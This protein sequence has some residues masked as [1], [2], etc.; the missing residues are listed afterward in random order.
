MRV[1]ESDDLLWLITDLEGGK[2][3]GCLKAFCEAKNSYSAVLLYRGRAV[4]CIYESELEAD[5]LPTEHSLQKMLMDCQTPG[6]QLLMYSL[7]DEVILAMSA[8][9]VGYP[10]ERA[11]DLD[12]RSYTDFIMRWFVA[13]QQTACLAF[14]LPIREET[15]LAL[16]HKGIIAGAFHVQNQ[17]FSRDINFIFNLI[18]QDPQ[19]RVEASILPPEI[20]SGYGFKL[21]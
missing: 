11:D 6:T 9:F 2:R 14:S 18:Q 10:V 15:L 1:N 12:A 7:P 5:L 13:N 16:I 20:P 19:A 8:M 17:E 3:T 4:C 21:S